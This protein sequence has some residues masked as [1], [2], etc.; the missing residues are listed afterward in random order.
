MTNRFSPSGLK[1]EYIQ[2]N[3]I[4]HADR[5]DRLDK[6]VTHLQNFISWVDRKGWQDVTSQEPDKSLIPVC[7]IY[8]TM[9]ACCS[10]IRSVCECDF[11]LF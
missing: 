5:D 10:D 1:I 8:E 11:S 4:E 9:K 2:T 3:F 7:K 6:I